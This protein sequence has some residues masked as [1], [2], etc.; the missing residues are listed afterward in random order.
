MPIAS[1]DTFISNLVPEAAHA[2]ASLPTDARHN[3]RSRSHMAL[4]SVA[5]SVP[6]FISEIR[7]QVLLAGP[8]AICEGDNRNV[9][10]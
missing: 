2:R 6:A 10:P 7:T 5:V 4:Q 9:N 8:L 1:C 3:G